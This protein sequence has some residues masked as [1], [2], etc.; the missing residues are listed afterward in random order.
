MNMKKIVIYQ[1]KDIANVDYAFRSF[2]EKKFNFNDY[3]K[4]CGFK[5]ERMNDMTDSEVAEEVFVSSNVGAL[6]I[7]YGHTLSVSD[8]VEVDNSYF[9]CDLCGWKDIT[10]K[11]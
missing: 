8:I 2:D 7:P 1:I 4:V 11:I 5:T 9:Y 10:D 6:Q 3:E